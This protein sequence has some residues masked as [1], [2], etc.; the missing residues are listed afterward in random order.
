LVKAKH[1]YLEHEEII[2]TYSRRFKFLPQHI[3]WFSSSSAHKHG[4]SDGYTW[5]Q[6]VM[7]LFWHYADILS[8]N[9]VQEVIVL[10]LML[11]NDSSELCCH[12]MEGGNK[13]YV[14]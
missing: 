12:I 3:N 11:L 14:W 8:R 4:L 6:L 10:C 7:P 2:E 13:T 1:I 9:N 5:H